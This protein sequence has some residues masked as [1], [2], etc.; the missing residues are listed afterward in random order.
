MA[1]NSDSKKPEVLL[2]QGPA[3]RFGQRRQIPPAPAP[4]TFNNLAGVAETIQQSVINPAEERARR[5]ASSTPLPPRVEKE[6]AKP[7]E[8]SKLAK[9]LGVDGL[10]E[11]F[12]ALALDTRM[13]RYSKVPVPGLLETRARGAASAAFEAREDAND[14]Y[15]AADAF[16]KRNRS[17]DAETNAARVK[18]NVATTRDILTLARHDYSDLVNTEKKN[19]TAAAMEVIE[20]IEDANTANGHAVSTMLDAS[21]RELMVA[22]R[23]EREGNMPYKSG[24]APFKEYVIPKSDDV[25]VVL[26]PREQRRANI[27]KA[28]DQIDSDVKEMKKIQATHGQGNYTYTGQVSPLLVGDFLST[29]SKDMKDGYLNNNPKNEIDYGSLKIVPMDSNQVK[30]LGMAAA[31]DHL[32]KALRTPGGAAV[33]EALAQD[34]A[35]VS[36]MLT[37]KANHTSKLQGP[38]PLR[39]GPKTSR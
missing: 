37:G 28:Q 24:A 20:N 29:L 34:I 15:G 35:H 23:A 18:G 33:D 13:P 6:D 14:H 32:E 31:V 36:E 22:F 7:A 27:N 3:P 17:K 9:E 10:L 39:P 21:Y 5:R 38:L 1:D 25:P 30:A 4:G 16:T 26:T 2:A 12:F 8:P 11:R 19:R